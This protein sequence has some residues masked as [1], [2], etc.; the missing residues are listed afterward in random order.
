MVV[1]RWGE[2]GEMIGCVV[3]VSKRGLFLFRCSISFFFWGV[4]GSPRSFL[5]PFPFFSKA[6]RLLMNGT[7]RQTR[8][9]PSSNAR[10]VS[11]LGLTPDA[12]RPRST[13]FR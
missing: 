5:S 12:D 9:S 11:T 4:G 10:I 6:S 13:S 2:R 3:M 8:G 7:A 1:W